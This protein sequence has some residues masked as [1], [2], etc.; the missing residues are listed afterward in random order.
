MSS[1][2][3]EEA[4]GLRAALRAVSSHGGS[5]CFATTGDVPALAVF[6]S[7]MRAVP[8]GNLWDSLWIPE[9]QRYGKKDASLSDTCSLWGSKPVFI[10]SGYFKHL[11]FSQR[12][13]S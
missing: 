8:Q 12:K 9:D 4:G 7:S 6:F 3:L 2:F 5:L 1:G 11:F 10:T 13:N